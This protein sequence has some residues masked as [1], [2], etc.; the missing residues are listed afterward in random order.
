M[1][2]IKYINF[3]EINPVVIEIWGVENENGDLAV[4]IN[5]TLVCR[6]SF[7]TADMWLCVLIIMVSLNSAKG[8]KI[9][10]IGWKYFTAM[11]VFE[12]WI[13]Q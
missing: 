3:I 6:T 9:V 12:Q 1:E 8:T 11:N 13:L 2:G 10:K 7:L 4:P 5:N